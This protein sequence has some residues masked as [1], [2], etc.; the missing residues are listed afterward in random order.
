MPGKAKIIYYGRGT[1]KRCNQRQPLLVTGKV[2]PH[3]I[4]GN[5]RGASRCAGTALAPKE[6]S[7]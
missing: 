5:A 7:R 1:C 3:P 2:A 6:V 4:P